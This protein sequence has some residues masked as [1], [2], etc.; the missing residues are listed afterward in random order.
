MSENKQH[1]DHSKLLLYLRKELNSEEK[2]AVDLW[3]KADAQN[4]DELN[5]LQKIWIETGKLK[6]PPVAVDSKMAWEK[7]SGKID[8][9]EQ[10]NEESEP[11]SIK[12]NNTLRYT[13]SI[14]ASVIV[15][16]SAFYWFEIRN[17]QPQISVIASNDITIED[18]LTDGSSI[19]LNK[20]SELR[21]SE[22]FNKEERRV[23]LKGEAFFDVT[24]NKEKPFIV[25]TELGDVRVLGTRF[26]VKA[27]PEEDVEVSVEEGRVEV[28]NI[29]PNTLDTIGVVLNAGEQ[30]WIYRDGFIPKR[31]QIL[32][33][34]AIFWL[35]KMLIF[36]KTELSYVFEILEKHYELDVAVND[37]SIYNLKLT[38]TFRN[39]SIENIMNVIALSFDLE[40]IKDKEGFKLILKEDEIV[41][42][43][44]DK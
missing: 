7:L 37:S 8:E 17:Q 41:E 14:A 34:D 10:S 35:N 22:N 31:S 40:I 26:N 27:Y 21:R 25:E 15:L 4:Q 33:P 30:G 18:T 43:E 3:L 1:I 28:F 9:W 32:K 2:E 19:S 36:K 24:S 16:I 38:A 20:N 6:P 42:T 11:I 29:D 13:I 23:E 39:E 44:P 5:T 12:R